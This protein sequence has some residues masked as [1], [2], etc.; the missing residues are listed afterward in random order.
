MKRLILLRHAK[1]SWADESLADNERPLA[2]RGLRDA[3]KMAKRLAQHGVCPDVFVT[4]DARRARQTAELVAGR[5]P[6][7]DAEIRADPR[8]YHASPGEL[9]D[10]VASF[11]DS[12]QE[13]VLVGHNP[14]FT[15]VAN[16]M[17]PGLRLANL[18]T[19]GVIAIDCDT[20][21]WRDVSACSPSLA[22]Y[23]YPKNRDPVR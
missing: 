7:H 6:G 22:F 10:I 4:S 8:V 11:D 19:T 16:L 14:G 2:E 18:P 9:L 5:L 1:S 17:L 12:W 3:P 13:V 20:A 21:H 15:Q 23:D